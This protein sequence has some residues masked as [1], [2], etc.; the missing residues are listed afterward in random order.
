MRNPQDSLSRPAI[1]D[2]ADPGTSSARVADFA[3]VALL[4]LY[5]SAIFRGIVDMSAGGAD[6]DSDLGTYAFSMAGL[7]QP[8][9]FA[10]DPILRG[11]T[12]ANSFWNLFQCLGTLCT[13]GQA[14]AVGLLRAGA[15]TIL[16]GH[17][18]AYALGRRLFGAPGLAAVFSLLMGMTVW[19]GW[20]TF[21][22]LTHSDP[23]P[24]TLYAALWPLLLM[25]A[26]RAAER[27]TLRPPAML[28]AGLGVWVHGIS[29][30]AFGGM[31]FCAFL[32]IRPA[33][34]SRARHMG[35]L[36]I[37]LAAYFLPVLLFLRASLGQAHPFGSDDMAVFRELFALRWA[38]DYS[39]SFTDIGGYLLKY[40][41]WP[42]IFVLGLAGGLACLLL[43]DERARCWLRLCPGM[44]LGL[45]G[46]ILFSWAETRF[47]AEYGRLPMGHELV[48]GLR[49]LVPL[50]WMG[51]VAGASLFWRRIPW[52]GRA[53]VV[54]G[55][56]LALFLGSPD[57][58]NVAAQHALSQWTGLPLPYAD[59]ALKLR[60]Q[61]R[62]HREALEAVAAHVPPGERVFSPS[63]DMGV[64]HIA[65]RPLGHT[66]K[67]GSHP[68]YNKNVAA[69]RLWLRMEALRRDGGPAAMWR[70]DGSPWMLCDRPEDGD[71]LLRE[72]RVV[73][74][75][76]DRMLLRALKRNR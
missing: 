9:L 73:W 36:A 20:G 33:G 68:F 46:V 54:A 74:E 58:Q 28:L 3:F 67:D 19:V 15:L 5:V 41:F 14:Y 34:I 76:A 32:T 62:S 44:L 23:V 39:H 4:L 60:G 26:I 52:P 21:W 57:R 70:A 11:L 37:C 42:P 2:A 29:G 1:G 22:G 45:C 35:C 47:A 25:F 31:L 65:L 48:R 69:G 55:L 24:R 40:A 27:P 71:I 30:L 7:A 61:A 13:D 72:G 6:L 8:G 53:A 38:R 66:F 18:S 50:S 43:R 12:P 59:R 63:G 17:L 51:I 49:F 64:R 10:N 56:A 16:V 75:N